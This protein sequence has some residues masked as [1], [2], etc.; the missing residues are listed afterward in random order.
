MATLLERLARGEV[1]LADG[2]MGTLL[3]AGGLERGAV[4]ESLNLSRPELLEGIARSYLEAG[5]DIVQTNTFGASPLKLARCGLADRSAE[6]NEA[7]VRA[8]RRAVGDRA[9]VAASC[10]PCGRL[11]RPYGDTEEEEMAESFRSQMQALWSAGID[12]FCIETMSDIRE[13]RLAVQAARS[14]SPTA[15]VMATMTFEPT[16]RGF[17]TVMG[18][19]IETACSELEKAG[20]DLVGSNCGNGSEQ[21]VAIAREFRKWSRRPLVIQANAGLPELRRGEVH[22]PET[23]EFMARKALELRAAGA[24]VIGGCCGTTPEHT[25]AMRRALDGSRKDRSSLG[26]V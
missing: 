24:A 1:L 14:L 11:L 8:A 16:P 3:M 23:P 20:A 9:Y 25:R 21:M 26:S 13:A 6:I 22:Y 12:A 19:T 4:P 5:A 7:A 17:F 15:P 18:V 10:G 2:A